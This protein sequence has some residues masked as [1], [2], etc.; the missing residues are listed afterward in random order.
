[1]T[2]PPIRRDPELMDQ[3]VTEP[4]SRRGPTGFIDVLRFFGLARRRVPVAVVGRQ[5]YVRWWE[6]IRATIL[7]TAIVIGMGFVVAA[8]IGVAVLGAGFLLEQAIS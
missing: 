1:M 6:R 2:A 8:A 4:T 5:A 7:L 3:P